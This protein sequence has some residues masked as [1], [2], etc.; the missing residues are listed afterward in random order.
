MSLSALLPVHEKH[1]PR[2]AK[3]RFMERDIKTRSKSRA[4]VESLAEQRAAKLEAEQPS[5]M[6]QTALTNLT[7]EMLLND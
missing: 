5:T 7:A 1:A 3:Q 6:N 4:V 2:S